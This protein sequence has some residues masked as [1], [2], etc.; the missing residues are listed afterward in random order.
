MAASG[1]VQYAFLFLM[2][3]GICSISRQVLCGSSYGDGSV[4]SVDLFLFGRCC[5][6]TCLNCTIVNF[7]IKF[8]WIKVGRYLICLDARFAWLDARFAWLNVR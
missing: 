4:A 2:L 8:I 7:F 3:G 1:L 5:I 6:F